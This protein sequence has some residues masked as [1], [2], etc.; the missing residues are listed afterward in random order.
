MKKSDTR[1]ASITAKDGTK[2]WFDIPNGTAEKVLRLQKI[3]REQR[4]KKKNPKSD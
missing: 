2:H 4:A 1:K 3:I